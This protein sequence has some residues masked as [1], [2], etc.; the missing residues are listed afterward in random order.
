M[1]DPTFSRARII[2]VNRFYWPEEPATAQLL[3]DLAEA[4][5]GA[6]HRVTVI[7]SHSGRPE[8]PRTDVRNGVEIKRV[9][10]TRWATAGALGKAIDFLTFYLGAFETLLFTA[11]KGDAVIVLTDPPLIGVGAWLAARMRGARIFHW[12][13]DIYPE[14][15]MELTGH[16]WLGLTRPLRNAA[17]RNA[18]GCVVLGADMKALLVENGTPASRIT[19]SPNWAPAGLGRSEQS[20]AGPLRAEWNLA[21]QFVVA[22]SGNLGRV[23]DLEPVIE[24]AA[25]LRDEPKI[26]FLFIGGGAQRDR[27]QSLAAARQLTRVQFRPSQPRERL[28]ETLALGDVHLVT[29]LPGCERLVFPSKLYGVTAAGR[30]VIFIGPRNS[31]LARE[32]ERGGFGH[33]FER[34]EIERMAA[35]IRA[36]S[37][38]ASAVDRL[39]RASLAFAPSHL[40]PTRAVGEWETLLGSGTAARPRL[41]QSA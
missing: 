6:G 5:A 23:H 25:A 17:W 18:D 41:P 19:I 38:D 36:L 10:G 40:G 13:Q 27:L 11:T 31:E 22:Y 39:A 33:A 37:R 1:A 8:L 28:D 12:V 30:P 16:R 21:G 2:F 35:T 3:T 4:L 29:L 34:G 26:S 14:I 7:A 20:A 15:A 9:R 24:L 32:I